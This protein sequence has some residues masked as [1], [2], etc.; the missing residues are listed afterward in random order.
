LP[1]EE[2]ASDTG[3]NGETKP[4][5]GDSPT[6]VT[7]PRFKSG[8]YTVKVVCEPDEYEDFD[9]YN[10]IVDVKIENDVISAVENVSGDGAKSNQR[11]IK[12]AASGLQDQLINR[13][14]ISGE[15]GIDAVSGAT[16]TS[17]AI[18]RACARALEQAR[19]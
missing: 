18:A 14:D 9:P 3:E 10:L 7:Q 15:D 2:P 6:A 11:Y 5:S 19:S 16:C 13:N 1:G 8:T 4:G 17:I 12:K